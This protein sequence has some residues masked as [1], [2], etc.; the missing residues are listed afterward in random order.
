MQTMM[1]ALAAAPS[2]QGSNIGLGVA[3]GGRILMLKCCQ[4]E[5]RYHRS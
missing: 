2:L 3:I 1:S 4:Q 5:L